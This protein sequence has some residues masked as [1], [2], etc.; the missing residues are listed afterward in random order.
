M[1]ARS[2]EL[3]IQPSLYQSL[4]KECVTRKGKYISVEERWED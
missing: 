1:I 4:K 2:I 3:A